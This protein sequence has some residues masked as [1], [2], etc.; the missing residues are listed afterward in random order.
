MVNCRLCAMRVLTNKIPQE[1]IPHLT[2]LYY[3]KGVCDH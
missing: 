3:Y 1:N 2:A